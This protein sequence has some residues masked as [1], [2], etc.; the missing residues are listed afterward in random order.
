ML[1]RRQFLGRSTTVL[2][3]IPIASAC[4]SDDTNHTPPP[5]Q[6][7][8]P[9]AEVIAPDA[10]TGGGCLEETST[11][12]DSHVHM[13][14]VRTDDLANPPPTGVTYTTT[15]VSA[16]THTITLSAAQLTSI[17]GGTEVTV[18]TSVTVDPVNGD[19]H[20]HQ[21]MIVKM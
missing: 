10:P 15:D 12:V 16:H 3:L 5:T 6:P 21:F 20:S 17:N 8:T 13:V 2:L 4:D 1:T 14:C 9:D 19:P 18:T 7:L 11:L